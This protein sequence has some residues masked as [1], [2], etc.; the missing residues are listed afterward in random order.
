M[1]WVNPDYV[2][3]FFLDEIGNYMMGAAILL[4]VIGYAIMQKIVNIDVT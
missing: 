4:Q 2:R 3:F 1:F